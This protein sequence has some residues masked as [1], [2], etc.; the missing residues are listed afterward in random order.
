[1]FDLIFLGF[2][3]LLLHKKL[4]SIWFIWFVIVSI[5]VVKTRWK[6]ICEKDWTRNTVV[7]CIFIY[8]CIT[9]PLPEPGW[10]CLPLIPSTQEAAWSTHFEDSQSY[11]ER[12]CPK[13]AKQTNKQPWTANTWVTV[14]CGFTVLSKSLTLDSSVTMTAF[15][16]SWAMVLTACSQESVRLECLACSPGTQ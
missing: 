1:M 16:Y 12:P 15:C 7:E 6:R 5:R 3:S 11:V 8:F 4:V 10:W 2:T 14:W 13:I 9:K